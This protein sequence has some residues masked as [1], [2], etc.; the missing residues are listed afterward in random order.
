MMSILARP[1]STTD[2]RAPNHRFCEKGF[3][4]DP[5]NKTKSVVYTEEG[6]CESERLFR[7]HLVIPDRKNN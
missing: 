6:L 4:C 1:Q 7:Q 2:L 3:V 5:V